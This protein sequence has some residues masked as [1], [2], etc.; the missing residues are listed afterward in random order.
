[1]LSKSRGAKRL[2]SA[3]ADISEMENFSKIH[4]W[5]NPSGTMMA[6]HAYNKA[7]VMFVREV[8]GDTRSLKPFEGKKML[9]VGCGG[10]LLSEVRSFSVFRDLLV[11]SEA[12]RECDWD[13]RE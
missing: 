10:G 13:R 1:M 6:L 12:R 11:S 4:D 5:W 2:F 7:R 3:K 9:D 8:I